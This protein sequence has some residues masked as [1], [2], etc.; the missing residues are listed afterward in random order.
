MKIKDLMKIKTHKLHERVKQTVSS[1]RCTIYGAITRCIFQGSDHVCHKQ[2][3]T[4][5][6]PYFLRFTNIRHF[7]HAIHILN[8]Y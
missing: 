2:L 4:K 1:F 7:E 5:E 8:S 6:Q 3:Q